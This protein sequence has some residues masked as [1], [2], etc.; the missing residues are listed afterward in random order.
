MDFARSAGVHQLV[1]FHHDPSH[2]DAD[3]EV[4]A[5]DAPAH[6]DGADAPRLAA[7]DMV[8]DLE[9]G[10][11]SFSSVEEPERPLLLA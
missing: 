3:L 8:V 2:T 9:P 11:V 10:R 7:D 1:L 5:A 4:M 6:W